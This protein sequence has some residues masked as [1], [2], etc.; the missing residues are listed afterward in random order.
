MTADKHK[1]PS[2][3]QIF[4][5]YL[6]YT[7]RRRTQERTMVL[8]CVETLQGHFTADDVVGLLS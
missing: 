7:R 6:Q 5:Q 2:D 1:S 4:D 3:E 8:D